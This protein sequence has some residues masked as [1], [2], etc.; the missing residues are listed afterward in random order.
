L[1]ESFFYQRKFFVTGQ[2]AR[3]LRKCRPRPSSQWHLDE[4]VV[5]IGGQHFCLWRAVDSEGEVLDLLLQRRRD[6]A[7]AITFLRKL[8]KKQGYALALAGGDFIGGIAGPCEALWR[9]WTYPTRR[10]STCKAY[11]LAGRR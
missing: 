10:P 2:F 9:T 4:L 1:E 6:K 5:V 7:A 11:W 3:E 8:S